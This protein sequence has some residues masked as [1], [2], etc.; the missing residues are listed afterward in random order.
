LVFSKKSTYLDHAPENAKKENNI[1]KAAFAEARIQ[2]L[3]IAL[4]L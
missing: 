4:A 3:L 2:N 1:M